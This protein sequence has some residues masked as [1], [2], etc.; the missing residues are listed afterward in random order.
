MKVM[1]YHDESKA[2]ARSPNDIINMMETI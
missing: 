2:H 1:T